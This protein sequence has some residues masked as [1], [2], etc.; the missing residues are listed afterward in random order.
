M[1][2]PRIALG[3]LGG[4]IAMTPA[5][6]GGAAPSLEAAGLLAAVPGLG[7]TVDVVAKAIAN[8]GSPSITFA[9]LLDALAFA[10]DSVDSGATG[11][12]LTHGTDTLE[13]SAFFLD[14]LWDRSAPLV[15]TGAMR[16]A[17][18]PGADGPANIMTA[19]RAATCTELRGCGVLVGLDDEIHLARTV[20][21]AH[22]SATSA[23][24]SPDWGP[25]ARVFE[26][27]V[28]VM[29]KPV[30]TP[31]SLPTPTAMGSLRVPVME[32]GLDAEGDSIR[33][34]TASGID[35]LVLAGAGLGHL[36]VPM[37]DAAQ[38]AVQAGLPVVIAT[39]QGAG[40]VGQK[41]YNYPGSEMDLL[42]RGLIGAGYLPPRKARVL[43]MTL[44]GLGLDG[45]AI[46]EEFARRV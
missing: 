33:A 19:V 31:T 27:A 14:L 24:T 9:H 20:T 23:F 21:K 5:A 30:A 6:G 4:T 28:H 10:Q 22:A 15:L 17:A 3:S 12:V 34:L 43:L 40:S 1:D 39:R 45:P 7:A 37:A 18:E 32:M 29:A 36:S 25:I 35:G 2:K 44:L 26:G 38:E 46:R 11:V 42:D 8:V 41:T 13:E 16:A